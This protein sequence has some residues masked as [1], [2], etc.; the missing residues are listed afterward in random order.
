MVL[1][2]CNKV[3]KGKLRFG[4]AKFS[5]MDCQFA[6]I[7]YNKCVATFWQRLLPTKHEMP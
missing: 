1:A 4:C 7:C 5:K 6:G 2:P 3:I